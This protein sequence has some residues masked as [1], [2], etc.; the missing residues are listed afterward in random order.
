MS[1]SLLDL[2]H[3]EPN[4]SRRATPTSTFQH[5][6]GHPQAIAQD[7]I[8]YFDYEQRFSV[9]LPG[10]PTIEEA[11][12]VSLRGDSYPQRI[13]RANEGESSY[14]VKVIDYTSPPAELA[15]GAAVVDVRS[16][17]AWEAWH[18]RVAARDAGGQIT[19]DGYAQIDRIEGHQ[20]QI[21]NADQS[22]TFITIH[23]LGRRLYVLEASVPERAPRPMLFQ[24]SLQMLDENG[25]RV[26]FEIDADGQRTVEERPTLR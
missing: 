11:S 13:Y 6:P 14:V 18:Y 25:D 16:A 7:W 4:G 26:R 2:Q 15:E 9:N 20:L 22:H 12:I 1:F 5:R 8:N 24:A 19:F 17:V 21:T 23:L 10:E 3:P